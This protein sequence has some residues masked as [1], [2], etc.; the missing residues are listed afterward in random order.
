MKSK[1]IRIYWCIKSGILHIRYNISRRIKSFHNIPKYSSESATYLT[2]YRH[3]YS[4]K[5]DEIG[6]RLKVH[7]FDVHGLHSCSRIFVNPPYRFWPLTNMTI[8]NWW[9]WFTLQTRP[10]SLSLRFLT[11]H[12]AETSEKRDTD[13]VI[14]NANVSVVR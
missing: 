10:V 1:N 9:C 3:Q 13:G 14:T 12:C 6:V 2:I 7:V 4:T 11:P 8:Y 5:Y